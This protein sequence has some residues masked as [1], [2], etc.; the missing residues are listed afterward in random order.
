MNKNIMFFGALVLAQ[1]MSASCSDNAS[2]AVIQISPAPISRTV[3]S[4]NAATNSFS[5]TDESIEIIDVVSVKNSFVL[6]EGQMSPLELPISALT[7][8]KLIASGLPSDR[9]SPLELPISALARNEGCLE[10][11]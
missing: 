4:V 10:R 5:D 3:A 7:L 8:A 1:N 9:I 6:P 11:R 2:G